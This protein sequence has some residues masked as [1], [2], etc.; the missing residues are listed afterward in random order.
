MTTPSLADRL[1]M[2][3]KPPGPPVMFQEWSHLLFLHWEIEAAEIQKRLPDGLFADQYEGKCYLGLVPFLM[4]KVRPR[5]LPTVPWLSNFLELNVRTYVHD[6]EG[7]PGVWFF[8]LDCDQPVAVELARNLFHLPYQHARMSVKGPRYSCRRKSEKE[9]AVFR[10]HV[11]GPY[12]LAK[13]GSLEFFLLERYLLFS[14]TRKGD[15]RCG[16]VHHEP[17]RFARLPEPPEHSTLPFQWEGFETSG[18]LVSSL[19]SPGV[20]VKIHPLEKASSR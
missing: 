8:S 1:A 18:P 9:T 7:R 4:Q 16:R 20:P 2:R 19:V 3:E 13:P 11:T 10:Y 12:E 6:A 14:A 17:Y 5:F 15:I